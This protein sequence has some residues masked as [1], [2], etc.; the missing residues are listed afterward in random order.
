MDVAT[1]AETLEAL[2]SALGEITS[3]RAQLARLRVMIERAPATPP[4]TIRVPGLWSGKRPR[5]IAVRE[6]ARVVRRW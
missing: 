4:P 1:E 5:E 6:N 3:I 2:A